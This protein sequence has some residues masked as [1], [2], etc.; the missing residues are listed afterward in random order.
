VTYGQ[1]AGIFTAALVAAVVLGWW[2]PAWYAPSGPVLVGAVVLPMLWLLGYRYAN[3]P[4]WALPILALAGLA[5]LI[6]QAT[7]IRT[8]SGVKPV[9]AVAV[10]TVLVA[11]PVLVWGVL[12]SIKAAAEPSYGY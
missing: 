12:T 8:W 7:T 9:L 3:L 5:P 4:V 10:V 11:S 6:I 2:K 1:F